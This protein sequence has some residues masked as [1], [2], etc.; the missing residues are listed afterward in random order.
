MQT[1]SRLAVALSREVAIGAA[2]K[3]D[4]QS[5]AGAWLEQQT[6]VNQC[7]VISG[8]AEANGAALERP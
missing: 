4:S 1:Y 3:A 8:Q 6:T 7:R 2:F 5:G